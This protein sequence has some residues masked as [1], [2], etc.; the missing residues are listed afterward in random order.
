MQEELARVILFTITMSV[1]AVVCILPLGIPLAWILARGNWRGKAL[2]ETLVSL[3]L[4]LPPVA[5]GLI[6]LKLLGRRGPLGRFFE[7]LGIE[8]AF[9]WKA[10][11]VASAVMAFPLLVRTAR[12]SFENVDLRLESLAR[13]LGKG[14]WGVFWSVSLPLASRG[15]LAATLL[16]F[17]RALGEFGATMMVA[18]NIQGETSTLSLSIY[19]LI[20]LGEDSQAWTLCGISIGIAFLAVLASELLNQKA[21]ARET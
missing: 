19:H 13:T 5:V 18:G 21:R 6:L 11:V 3:P 14:P 17:A 7:S 20:Q 1:I 8:V 10:V 2:V 4:V 9:T 15:I 16:A 12:T